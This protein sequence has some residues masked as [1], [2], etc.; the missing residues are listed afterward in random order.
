LISTIS[1]SAIGLTS[2]LL[3]AVKLLG[4]KHSN[5]LGF[6]PDGAFEDHAARGHLLAASVGETGLVG[7]CA[8]RVSKGRAMI[9]HLCVAETHRG[10]GVAKRLF[11]GV[12]AHAQERD[13]RGIGL[14]C[15]RD[16]PAY[17]MWPKLGFAPIG[18]KPG[19]GA[20]GIELTFWWHDFHAEDLF[21]PFEDADDRLR[22]VMDCNIFRDLHDTSEERNEEAKFLRADWLSGQ[23]E[24]CIV[25]E[26]FIEL[27]RLVL[28]HPREPLRRDARCYHVLEHDS[29]RAASIYEELK[30]IFEHPS[31]S[32]KQ[33]SDMRHVAMSAA[34]EAEVF[35]TRDEEVLSHAAEIGER[36]GLQVMRPVE[37]IS[38]L[39]ETEQAA[40]YQPARFASTDIQKVRPRPDDLGVLAEKLHAPSQRETRVQFEAKLRAILCDVQNT[41]VAAETD[42]APLFLIAHRQ[43]AT[44]CEILA[45][46]CNRTALSATALR[47]AILQITTETAKLGGR[48]IVVRDSLLSE[49]VQSV[50]HELGFRIGG[51]GWEKVTL[52]FL[53]DSLALAKALKGLGQPDVSANTVGAEIEAQY[54]PAKVLGAN[55]VTWAIPIRSAWA[56]ALFETSFADEQLFRPKRELILSR[57]NVYYSAAIQSGMEGGIGR[58]LWYVSTKDPYQAGA[59]TIRACSRLLE[60][61]RGPAKVL[62]NAF[63]RLGVF[64]WEQIRDMV[65]GDPMKEI[66]ALRFADT[67]LFEQPFPGDQAKALGIL[68]NFTS[69]VKVPE[70]SFVEIYRQGMKFPVRP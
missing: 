64:E 33:E 43:T 25:N 39:N 47:H 51:E 24:L 50:L 27:D 61:R 32:R 41:V 58:L 52:R 56:T 18:S 1:I 15:R 42:G 53:G 65:D 14:H 69:P 45:L 59:K 9:V 2:P 46:R 66:L 23:I 13:L 36:Y 55:V 67:E 12:K 21:T 20:D 48:P 34:A 26:L 68:N 28:P 29:T 19:R 35:L 31:P 57:E 8:F 60:V 70:T 22:V 11:A 49:E 37:L 7:Y 54:W 17:N 16:Y 5:T 4:R 10:A 38:R 3:S 62:F 30:Q 6:F 40:L 44:R 63:R